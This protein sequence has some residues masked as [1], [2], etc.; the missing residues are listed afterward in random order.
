LLGL[1]VAVLVVNLVVFGITA[2]K[3][4]EGVPIENR[5]T[6]SVA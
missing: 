4:T 6:E 2:A 3:V 1:I 5:D